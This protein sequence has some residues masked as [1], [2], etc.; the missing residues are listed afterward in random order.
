MSHGVSDMHKTVD[1]P[2]TPAACW[3][4]PIEPTR[5]LA[6]SSD[7]GVPDPARLAA[8]VGDGLIETLSLPPP[9]RWAAAIHPDAGGDPTRVVWTETADPRAMPEAPDAVAAAA[10]VIGIETLLPTPDTGDPVATWLDLAEA[11]RDLGADGPILDPITGRWFDAQAIAQWTGTDREERP[12]E[13]LWSIRATRRESGRGVWLS[14]EG[15][16]RLGRPE[17]EMLEVPEDL[18]D[19]AAAL[20]D[21]LAG[22]ACD[23]APPRHR[24]WMVGPDLEV[25]VRT[26][27]E[28]LETVDERS[29][30]STVDR[31]GQVPTAHGSEIESVVV[32]GAEPR[33]AYRRIWT[34]PT[35]VLQ[36]VMRGS[37]VHRSRRAA[38]RQ[39]R[40]AQRHLDLVAAASSP[41]SSARV[42]LA[43][44]D[45]GT[46]ILW[47]VVERVLGDRW[48]VQPLDLAGRPAVGEPE[49]IIARSQVVDWR[50]EIDGLV[51]GPEEAAQ[52]AEALARGA[53][54]D[55]HG[56]EDPTP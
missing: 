49:A 46:S 11:L 34:A 30:G 18:A 24:G 45:E 55:E 7:P 43:G 6:W 35:E 56:S 36:A 3:T 20:L 13:L 22:Q 14:T 53:V 4:R 27:E 26:P 25:V 12:E 2:A 39:R 41:S 32:C 40:L 10:I 38:V 54:A 37:A 42:L 51:H 47:G 19:A 21:S 8:L 48:S 50:V 29:A 5:L 23:A 15:L 1:G 33:G 31:E 16:A 44:A 28:V 17:L 52:L 9:V